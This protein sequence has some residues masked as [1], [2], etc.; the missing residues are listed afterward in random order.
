MAT[1]PPSSVT[2]PPLHAQFLAHLAHL[3]EA[4]GDIDNLLVD[5]Y[6]AQL[7]QPR[8]HA[9]APTLATPLQKALLTIAAPP[10]SLTRI[11][12]ALLPLLPPLAPPHLTALLTAYWPALRHSGLNALLLPGAPAVSPAVL[13]Q[14]VV[15]A[16]TDEDTGV[17][18]AAGKVL[19][20]V[21]TAA[22]H[23]D[24]LWTALFTPTT[25]GLF[26][27]APPYRVLPLLP[28][29]MKHSWES[30]AHTQ[31]ETTERA[32][33]P[34]TASP[35]GGLAFWAL[36]TQLQ[37][38]SDAPVHALALET[39]GRI[40]ATPG[41]A[42]DAWR[43]ADATD[44]LDHAAHVFA[45]AS[46]YSVTER[47]AAAEALAAVCRVTPE[48][49]SK[50]SQDPLADR[51]TFALTTAGRPLGSPELI[52]L[53]ALPAA[54][55]HKPELVKL[56]AALPLSP[57]DA[58]TV[59]ALAALLPG[60][61][62]LRGAFMRAH[63]P[64]VVYTQLAHLAR[65]PA[66]GD[67]AVAGVHL[68]RELLKTAGR[69]GAEARKAAVKAWGGLLVQRAPRAWMGDETGRELAL[70]RRECVDAVLNWVGGG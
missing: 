10:D 56:V 46:A 1:H 54:V 18:D 63:T 44:A 64:D 17:S 45:P 2:V 7:S 69:G 5:T 27:T 41:H 53:T 21:L 37:N 15:L 62:V 12:D 61:A 9:A 68:I 3:V 47:R 33:V 60:D 36:T 49:L 4:P 39:V 13:H 66:H 8:L 52:L 26:F 6:R 25:Y 32:H 29:L 14:L 11:L 67:A 28:P 16:L 38:T 58:A 24:G 59:H 30:F 50:P 42:E 55:L 48:A 34:P 23:P 43:L 35:Y 51:L 65:T 57:P 70:A 40:Y 20:R 31:S 22:P 19:K